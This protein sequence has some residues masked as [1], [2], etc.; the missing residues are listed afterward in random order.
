MR[1]GGLGSSG[2]SLQILANILANFFNVINFNTLAQWGQGQVE[3]NF[4]RPF[5]TP[6]ALRA[7]Q[8]SLPNAQRELSPVPLLAP[9]TRALLRATRAL[10]FGLLPPIPK[11]EL[12]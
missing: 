4:A 1:F 9:D 5:R 8:L 12:K 7:Q 10:S 2:Q 6:V 3:E 11:F